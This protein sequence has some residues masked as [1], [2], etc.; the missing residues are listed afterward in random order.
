MLEGA[1]CPNCT[2]PIGNT[3]VR[4]RAPICPRCGVTI[5]IIDGKL[6]FISPYRVL[7][8]NTSRKLAQAN[9]A[10]FREQLSNYRGMQGDC[11][12]KLGW[13]LEQYA[14]FHK[15]LPEP[16]ALL[17]IQKT[18]GTQSIFFG[19]V[20]IIIGILGVFWTSP[21]VT[22]HVWVVGADG[23]MYDME[24]GSKLPFH[25]G[26]NVVADQIYHLRW[27]RV[28]HWHRGFSSAGYF[29]DWALPWWILCLCFILCVPFGLQFLVPF[30]KA[31]KANGDRPRENTRRTREYE[32]KTFAALREAK[33]AKETT[34][35]QLGDQIRE[36]EG[37]IRTVQI[38]EADVLRF[39]ETFKS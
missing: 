22:S 37:H 9:L 3:S 35:F 16:P 33:S 13:S 12:Q 6:G 14:A 39:L 11:N 10:V 1:L 23:W 20:P 27:D 26:T 25:P 19:V 31:V 8:T 18:D 15:M 29:P 38:H 30:L 36:L 21:W 17:E 34:D 2:S 7:D 28:G 24:T 5:T 32:K 4:A